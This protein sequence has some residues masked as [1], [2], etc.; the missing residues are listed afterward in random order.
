MITLKNEK[1]IS[2][3]NLICDSCGKTQQAP[4]DYEGGGLPCP[5]GWSGDDE[6]AE[7][8]MDSAFGIE[9]VHYH[10]G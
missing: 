6:W 10:F 3:Y 9:A 7:A 5:E 4:S 2:T 8:I 1:I